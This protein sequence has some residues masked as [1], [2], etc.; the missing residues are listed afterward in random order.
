MLGKAII[1]P[2]QVAANYKPKNNHETIAL[3]PKAGTLYYATLYLSDELP[4]DKGK[5]LFGVYDENWLDILFLS[6][7]RE[8]FCKIPKDKAI[9]VIYEKDEQYIGVVT[10]KRNHGKG[11]KMSSTGVM[12][13]TRKDT[14]NDYYVATFNEPG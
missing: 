13:L 5:E 2:I 7:F 6:N 4:V 3:P 12:W 8:T 11:R 10:R 1:I 9:A 14:V